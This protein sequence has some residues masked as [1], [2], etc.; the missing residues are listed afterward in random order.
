MFQEGAFPL[1]EYEM[2]LGSDECLTKEE[3]NAASVHRMTKKG[4]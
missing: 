1:R 3:S 2:S 4:E